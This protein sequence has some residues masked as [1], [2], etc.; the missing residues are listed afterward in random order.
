RQEWT[1]K[2]FLD[3]DQAAEA[4]LETDAQLAERYRKLPTGRGARYFQEKKLR[5]EARSKS[6]LAGKHVAEELYQAILSTG[7]EVKNLPARE[8][9]ARTRPLLLK[10]A[11]FIPRRNM[12]EVLEVARR[13]AKG[14]VPLDVE[15]SGPWP[16]YHFCPSLGEAPP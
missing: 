5:E 9:D 10:L 3:E 6:L 1:L 11:L 12:D 4:L 8:S 13:A 7:A 15:P 16:P 2:A 14:R